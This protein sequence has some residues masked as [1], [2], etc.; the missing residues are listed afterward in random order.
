MQN[1]KT[2]KRITSHSP[3]LRHMAVERQESRPPPPAAVLVSPRTTYVVAGTTHFSRSMSR[4]RAEE[5]LEN[6]PRQ[7]PTAYQAVEDL[8]IEYDCDNGEA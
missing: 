5:N 6:Q 2:D 7:V 1:I 3:T 4:S 8:E